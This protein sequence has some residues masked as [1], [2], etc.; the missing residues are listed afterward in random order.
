MRTRVI[1]LAVSL[2]L[3]SVSGSAGGADV[4][5]KRMPDGKLWTT[6]NLN[7]ETPDSYCY[8]DKAANCTRYGRLYTWAAAQRACPSL[9]AGWRLPTDDEWR[10]LATLFG[11]LREESADAGKSAYVALVIG[12]SSGFNAI[13][14]GNRNVND[15]QYARLDAHG[16][17]WTATETSPGHAWIYNF[18]KGGQSLNRHREGDPRMAVSVRCISD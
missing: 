14:G 4:S 8:D 1:A 10:R 17:Y 9:G 12:G 7:V 6:D 11:G 2:A 13:L 16:I 5:S 3:G 18:G 15:S